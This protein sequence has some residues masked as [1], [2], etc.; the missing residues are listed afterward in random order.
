MIDSGQNGRI[1][2]INGVPSS[3]CHLD[4]YDASR[5]GGEVV[6]T[7]TANKAKAD[8]CLR[9]LPESISTGVQAIIQERVNT[10]IIERQVLEQLIYR[11]T[12]MRIKR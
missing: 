12:R 4:F 1:C 10:T 7:L 3:R 6:I 11:Y 2:T 8:D 9:G 5:L